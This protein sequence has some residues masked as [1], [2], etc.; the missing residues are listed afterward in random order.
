L[1]KKSVAKR[2]RRLK[3]SNRIQ[4]YF[5]GKTHFRTQTW[6]LTDQI[7]C[8]VMTGDTAYFLTI[9][10][11][12][13]VSV[14]HCRYGPWSTL[15][16][17]AEDHSDDQKILR[18]FKCECSSPYLQQPVTDLHSESYTARVTISGD[19]HTPLSSSL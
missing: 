4:Y 12:R 15:P 18:P 14:R 16:R 19:L 1:K 10:P 7:T 13:T 3:T 2:L 9:R 8:S 6:A 17:E 5:I 11:T